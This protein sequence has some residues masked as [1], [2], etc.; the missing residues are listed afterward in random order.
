[1]TWNIQALRT[2]LRDPA[3][4][5]DLGSVIAAITTTTVGRPDPGDP[6]F[7]VRL[8]GVAR[9]GDDRIT[10]SGGVADYLSQVAPVPLDPA[11]S[12]AALIAETLGATVAL[13]DLKIR[14]NDGETLTR[15]FRDE[16]PIAGGRAL[17]L[18][19]VAFKAAS[20]P[21]RRSG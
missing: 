16:L 11:F 8:E 14:I 9:Q 19:E 3:D 20:T 17:V 5:R 15:A 12:G 10:S 1:M 6:F 13:G 7:E 21:R 4:R 18:R 2:A